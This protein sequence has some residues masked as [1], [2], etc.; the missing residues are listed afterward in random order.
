M[1]DEFPA[2]TQR[3][4][5]PFKTTNLKTTHDKDNNNSLFLPVT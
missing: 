4:F 5:S 1:G 2:T 3:N